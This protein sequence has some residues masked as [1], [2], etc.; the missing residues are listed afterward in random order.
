[1]QL[2]FSHIVC[3]EEVLWGSPRVNGRRLAVGDVVSLVS[4]YGT[5]E[6]VQ[7]DFELSVEEIREVL[8]YCSSLQC[9]RDWP[10]VYCH[11]CSL[12]KEP[13]D[14][15]EMQEVVVEGVAMV[16]HGD[17]LFVGT[18]GEYLLEL[19]GTDWWKVATDLLIDKRGKLN[20]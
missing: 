13:V 6:E 18:L 16:K 10:L 19:E 5:F 12:R 14:L 2:S 15:S 17:S 3:T 8:L 11:N 1:M 4:N 9:K 20:Q 7:Q